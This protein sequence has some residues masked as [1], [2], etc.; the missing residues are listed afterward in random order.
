MAVSLN[1]PE[2]FSI[3]G[4]GSSP[5]EIRSR[6]K[7]VFRHSSSLRRTGKSEAGK[8]EDASGMKVFHARE[9]DFLDGP[10]ALDNPT[11]NYIPPGYD[12]AAWHFA[13]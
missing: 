2:P 12:G 1:Y 10:P 4:G 7:G 11:A 6:R 13:C 3:S 8:V 5:R 9:G